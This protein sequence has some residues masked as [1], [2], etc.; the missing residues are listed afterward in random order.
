[1]TNAFPPAIRVCDLSKRYQVYDSPQDRLKQSVVPRLARFIRLQGRDYFREFWAL[2]DVSFDVGRGE[3]VGIVGRN[4]SGKSTLL[5]IICGTLT[6]TAGQIE[7]TGRV[8]ALLE[9]GS[10]FNPDFTGRENVYLNGRVLG[11]TKAQIDA[12]FDAIEEF[13][14]IGDFVNQPVRTYSSGMTVRL[15]FAVAINVDPEILVIDEALAVGDELFQRKCFSKIQEIRNKGATILFVSHSGSAVVELCDRAILLDDGE[16][17]AVGPPKTIIGCYQRLLY[18]DPEQRQSI[19]AEIGRSQDPLSNGPIHL[20]PVPH[21]SEVAEEPQ[22]TN[23]QQLDEL[24][25]SFDP[26]LVPTSTIAYVSRGALITQPEIWSI[27]GHRVN[28]LIRG[29]R[30]RYVYQVHFSAP[31]HGVRFGMLIKTV[32][33]VE[34][35]GAAT[36]ATMKS[37]LPHVASR[38]VY[39]VTFEFQCRLNTGVYFLNAGVVGL[40]GGT[41][42]YLH[43]LLDVAMFRVLPEADYIG[44]GTVDFD[45]TASMLPAHLD[46]RGAVAQHE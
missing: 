41:E 3:T 7:A 23:R 22:S 12:R 29:N 16:L 36:A 27:D 10:G 2:R 39:T 17:L 38:S 6:P 34:L 44:S 18:A 19:R 20:E 30:Y 11:L 8:A 45:C 28:N 43:R 1:M 32:S 40:L 14:G 33:G 31:A 21:R 42:T 46:A 26:S 35:G 25:E 13:A 4:G 9:L 24:V 37:A 15:A 5:Q